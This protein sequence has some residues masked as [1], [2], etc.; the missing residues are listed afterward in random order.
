MLEEVQ[1]PVTLDDSTMHGMRSGH[2]RMQKASAH[3]EVEIN[4]QSIDGRIA[5][6][7]ARRCC[8]NPVAYGGACTQR[9]GQTPLLTN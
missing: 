1:V 3:S 7:A 5:I 8:I 6:N 9:T 2:F 4:L